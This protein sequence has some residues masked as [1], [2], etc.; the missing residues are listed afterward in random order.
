MGYC[1]VSIIG[2]FSII[3]VNFRLLTFAKFM[4]SGKV[5]RSRQTKIYFI[6]H[7][8]DILKLC[9]NFNTS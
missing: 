8:E 7:P 5:V 6:F 9:L 1:Y 4:E 2:F 3:R